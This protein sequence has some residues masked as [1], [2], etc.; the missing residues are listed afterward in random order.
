MR[1]RNA[2][3]TEKT[4][5]KCISK[6]IVEMIRTGARRK[7]YIASAG[8][9]LPVGTQFEILVEDTRIGDL[10]PQGT[11]VIAEVKTSDPVRIGVCCRKCV[12]DGACNRLGYSYSEVAPLCS[13]ER[14][15]GKDVYF[16]PIEPYRT[17]L[18]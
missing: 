3:T 15:D 6:N 9:D 2:V 7:F 4:V 5:L 10:I 16:P 17:Q 13:H 11:L 18:Q 1:C 14:K 8:E 12:F